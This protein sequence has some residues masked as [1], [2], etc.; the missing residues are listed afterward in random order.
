MTSKSLSVLLSAALVAATFPFSSPA[1]AQ[2][3]Q[4][5]EDLIGARGSSLDGAL[6]RRGYKF[7]KNEGAASMYWN[8][9]R[10]SCISALVNNGR[11]DSI[12]RASASNCGRERDA[13]NHVVGVAIGVAAAGLIAAL[14][15]HHHGQDYRN[16]NEQY[17]RQFQRGY[18]DGSNGSQYARNDTEAYHAGYMAGEAERNRNHHH[19]NG[20]RPGHSAAPTH[21][22]E[23]AAER[24]CTKAL[25]K[26]LGSGVQ[27]SDLWIISTKMSEGA[28][29]VTVHVP[30]AEKPWACVFDS[31]M[32]LIR[33][34][35]MGEG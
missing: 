34:Q 27:A 25:A 24:S 11:V 12:Q 1:N 15:S 9:S 29:W 33:T 2:N 31:N 32:N 14:T 20:N 21:A 35:Y 30:S 6:E 3:V 13:G 4:G 16:N 8:P 10:S 23:N 26:E 22:P 5:M 17:N 7:A 19:S 28:L 18:D